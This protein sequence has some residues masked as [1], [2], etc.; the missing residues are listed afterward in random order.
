[1]NGTLIDSASIHAVVSAIARGRITNST[2]WEMYAIQEMTLGIIMRKRFM[3][4]PPPDLGQQKVSSLTDHIYDKL[5]ICISKNIPDA[6]KKRKA[7]G[8][9][10]KY[11]SEHKQEIRTC[12]SNLMQD[13]T[14]FQPFIDWAISEDWPY[15]VARLGGL[16]DN[17][18]STQV[19]GI[20]DLS[21][22]DYKEL[23]TLCSNFNVVKRWSD[24]FREKNKYPQE[25]G[26]IEGYIYSALIRGI[27]Y[28]ELAN[29]VGGEYVWHRIRDH[30]LSPVSSL[31]KYENLNDYK[32]HLYLAE[33]ICTGA[34]TE[35]KRDKTVQSWAD[36]LFRLRTRNLRIVKEN[37]KKKA[38]TSAINIAEKC[39]FTFPEGKLYK[40]VD[41]AMGCFP[42]L[43]GIA[44][45]SVTSIF[46]TSVGGEAVEAGVEFKVRPYSEKVHSKIKKVYNRH[47]IKTLASKGAKRMFAVNEEDVR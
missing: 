27:Y 39:N 15:H 35:K 18:F 14:N 22:A 36:N 21:K 7:L 43:V 38:L 8:L 6:T 41:K 10:K 31:T 11:V 42:T 33:I 44:V 16:I 1:M 19:A 5:N 17:S 4:T 25:D 23:K 45:G 20:L 24:T 32:T 29:Q 40:I 12:L 30:V 26:V 9:T 34:V 2:D 13:E 47:R 37:D 28:L 46:T 3:I